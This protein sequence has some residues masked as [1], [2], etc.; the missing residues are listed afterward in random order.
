MMT[1]ALCVLILVGLIF[2]P[3]H[4]WYFVVRDTINNRRNNKKGEIK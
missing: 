4:G 2:H 1:T 3:D